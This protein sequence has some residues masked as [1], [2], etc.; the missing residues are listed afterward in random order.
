MKKNLLSLIVLFS[1]ALVFS[2]DA[3]Y[4]KNNKNI[5]YLYVNASEGLRI[6]NKPSLSGNK[7]GVLYDRMK[8]KII[9][10]GA[11]TTIDGIKS[12][13]VQILLPIETIKSKADAYGWVFGGYLT[14]TLAPFSTKGWTDNDLQKY[15]SRFSW[16]TGPREYYEFAPDGS[17]LMGRL[18][19]GA[20]GNGEY[21]VSMKDKKITVKA[22]YGDEEYE[23]EVITEIYKITK[24]EEDKITLKINDNEFTLRPS[25][26][27]DYFYSPLAWGNF[28]P[29][30]FEL[31]SY[32]ALMF[33]FTSDL[34]KNID[35]K[36]FIKNSSHNL[37]RMGILID[38]EEYLKNYN[39][40]WNK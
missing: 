35:S 15:L 17:Y 38:D 13:W 37:I 39:A 9:S 8:I 23:S 18:E 27:H 25:L 10:V 24:I 2:L 34:I 40:Y 26:T 12:N 6:R 32:N 28:N 4:F 36:D 16:V 11:E 3:G 22:S 14:D 29:G 7:I 31:S 33:S 30:S 19:S 20:G 5:D 1:S 21:T